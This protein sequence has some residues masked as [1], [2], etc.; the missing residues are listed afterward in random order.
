MSDADEDGEASPLYKKACIAAY[1]GVAAT[2][3][4]RTLDIIE[5]VF[6]K[7]GGIGHSSGKTSEGSSVGLTVRSAASGAAAGLRMLDGVRM[8]GPSLAKLCDVQV[9]G[10]KNPASSDNMSVASTLC[11]AIHRTTVKN[12]AR[13]LENLAKAI[14]EDPFDGDEY[15]PRDARIAPVS[16]DVVRAVRLISSFDSA[17]KSVTKRR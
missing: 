13:T 4:D 7:E 3:V 11:I 8:L 16:S 14:Q 15:R 6:L 1:S 10:K 9:V 2:V 17:Y 5:T 12:T